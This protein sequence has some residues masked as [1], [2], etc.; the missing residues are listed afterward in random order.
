MIDFIFVRGK[1]DVLRQ[2]TLSDN[3]NGD[4]ASDHLPVMAEIVSRK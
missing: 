1:I 4:L 3:W 2:A